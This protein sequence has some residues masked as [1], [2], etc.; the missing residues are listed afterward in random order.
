MEDVAS[1]AVAEPDDTGSA[2][3]TEGNT[4]TPQM[5]AEQKLQEAL[6]F[7]KK[8]EEQSAALQQWSKDLQEKLKTQEELMAKREAQL[9]WTPPKGAEATVPD[10]DSMNGDSSSGKEPKG[11]TISDKRTT[12]GEIPNL[13]E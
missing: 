10:Q 12:L 6:D 9:S 2:S 3:T 4:L 11:A 1:A 7:I 5:V 13:T 8:M